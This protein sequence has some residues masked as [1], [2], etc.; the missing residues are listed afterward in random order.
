MVP[1]SM[2]I[3]YRIAESASAKDRCIFSI[4]HLHHEVPG[5]S[6]YIYHSSQ[7]AQEVSNIGKGQ[8]T[9]GVQSSKA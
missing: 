4:L 1:A 9:K 2:I 5:P 3:I 6:K 7:E 8:E